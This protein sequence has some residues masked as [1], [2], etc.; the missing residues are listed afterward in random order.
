VAYKLFYIYTFSRCAR[1][2]LLDVVRWAWIT[3]RA[4]C[5]PR[6]IITSHSTFLIHYSLRFDQ[7]G[8]GLK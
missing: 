1:Y 2:L 5:R 3:P 8:G 6:L 4:H 7:F